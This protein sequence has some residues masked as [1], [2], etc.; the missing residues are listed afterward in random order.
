MSRETA[1]RSVLISACLLLG[2]TAFWFVPSG[3]PRPQEPR[4]VPVVP[5]TPLASPAER[6]IALVIRHYRE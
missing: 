3:K 5:A 1:W 2:L 6:R 4:G